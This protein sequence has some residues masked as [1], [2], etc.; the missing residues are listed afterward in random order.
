MARDT[1]QALVVVKKKKESKGA[2]RVSG[3]GG[4]DG[5]GANGGGAL[6]YVY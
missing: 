4:A 1:S 2:R 5:G 6:S 3:L